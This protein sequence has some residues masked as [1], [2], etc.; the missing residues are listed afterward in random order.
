MKQKRHA[1]EFDFE[2]IVAKNNNL[3][4]QVDVKIAKLRS[5]LPEDIL[6]NILYFNS[7]N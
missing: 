7:L 2:A 6:A 1:F 4:N 5:E 3:N